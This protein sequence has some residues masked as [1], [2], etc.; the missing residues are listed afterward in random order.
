M[1]NLNEPTN[2]T[3]HI[4]HHGQAIERVSNYKLLGILLDQ[5]LNWEDQIKRVSSLV[6]CRLFVLRYFRRIASFR[7]RK[8]LLKDFQL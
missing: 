5:H 2:E 3:F 7:L 1:Y 6:Y 8:Q 4:N